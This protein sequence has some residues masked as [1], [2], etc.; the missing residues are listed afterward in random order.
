MTAPH[1]LRKRNRCGLDFIARSYEA[2][3]DGAA[4]PK[5]LAY[6]LL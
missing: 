2:M 6:S 1:T 3:L 5:L 4:P